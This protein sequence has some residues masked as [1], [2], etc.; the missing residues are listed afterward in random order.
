M[1]ATFSLLQSPTLVKRLLRLPTCK[2]RWK[3]SRAR[4][5]VPGTIGRVASCASIAATSG[6]TLTA[7][8]EPVAVDAGGSAADQRRPTLAYW[9]VGDEWL[10]AYQRGFHEIIARRIDAAGVPID[11]PLEPLLEVPESDPRPSFSE[12]AFA[13]PLF[14]DV[15]GYG[16]IA[17]VPG[18][19]DQGFWG[20]RLTCGEVGE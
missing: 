8:A 11:D 14:G 9:P 7:V 10:V 2:P 19:T 6:D 16:L 20:V 4:A 3:I 12:P 1:K 15:P 5:V 18:E 17:Y 13:F